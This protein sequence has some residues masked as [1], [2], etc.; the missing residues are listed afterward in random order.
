M[1]GRYSLL[2]TARYFSEDLDV[3][4]SYLPN[5]AQ[6]ASKRPIR[7]GLV[8]REII[9]LTIVPCILLSLMFPA[10]LGIRE[11]RDRAICA[12]NLKQLGLALHNFESQNGRLPPGCSENLLDLGA[13]TSAPEGQSLYAWS[14]FI[15]PYCEQGVAYD[16]LKDTSAGNLDFCFARESALAAL[17]MPS[18]TFRCPADVTA[19][20]VNY[21]RSFKIKP[22]ERAS[23]ALSNYVAA[24]HSGDLLAD[25]ASGANGLFY[26]HSRISFGAIPDGASSTIMLGE[27]AWSRDRGSRYQSLAATLYGVRSARERSFSGMADAMAGGRFR[28]NFTAIKQADGLGESYLRRAFSSNHSGGANFLF[29]DASVK[30]IKQDVD[31]DID[32]TTQCTRTP[33]VDSQFEA[34]LS[35]DDGVT[36]FE[37]Y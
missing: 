11:A 32:P 13:A 29:A 31:A 37:S 22:E 33:Q 24:N 35:I 26:H 6:N 12:N 14:A 8:L 1:I 21:G 3:S 20:R 18:A 9:A 4:M 2:K 28:I 30:F 17:Q 34:L 27:R 7:R 10:I 36:V 15:L 5:S 23:M 16:V 25:R 19:P